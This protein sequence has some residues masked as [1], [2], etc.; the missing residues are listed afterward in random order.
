MLL[1]CAMTRIGI[2]PLV[3][4]MRST[5]E[6]C[7][8]KPFAGASKIEDALALVLSNDS[9]NASSEMSSSSLMSII[10]LCSRE[11]NGDLNCVCGCV[12]P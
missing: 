6:T 9:A 11:C 3:D 8:A 10:S 7:P 4:V 2:D 12:K 1:H 5:T